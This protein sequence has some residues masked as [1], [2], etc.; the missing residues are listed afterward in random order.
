MVQCGWET[1]NSLVLLE[2]QV[3][4]RMWK[5][6]TEKL[7]RGIWC[8]CRRR[9]PWEFLRVRVVAKAQL[10]EG[11]SSPLVFFLSV[12]LAGDPDLL[13]RRASGSQAPSQHHSII[14]GSQWC[15]P[16]EHSSQG[17]SGPHLTTIFLVVSACQLPWNIWREC[18]FAEFYHM[19][20]LPDWVSNL[21]LKKKKRKKEKKKKTFPLMKSI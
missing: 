20:M 5:R 11:V 12:C 15:S 18:P 13:W 6:N 10:W 9:E 19:S 14:Q 4:G 2:G 7:A 16:A 21:F 17:W 8:L 3:Q 1:T